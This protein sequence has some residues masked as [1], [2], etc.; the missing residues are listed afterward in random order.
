MTNTLNNPTQT[1][2][3]DWPS[4]WH[5]GVETSKLADDVAQLIAGPIMAEA[6]ELREQGFYVPAAEAL[7]HASQVF[8]RYVNC[9]GADL[10]THADDSD[11]RAQLICMV[12]QHLST[13]PDAIDLDWSNHWSLFKLK[14]N[15][16][17][18]T[19][20]HLFHRLWLSGQTEALLVNIDAG[21]KEAY[22][23]W[24]RNR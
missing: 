20:A 19:Q 16:G 24:V 4:G 8:Q 21:R 15:E 14:H 3:S 13:M 5:L 11:E 10:D 22:A 2:P 17:T 23:E 1:W 18:W 7:M 12:V 6:A 9:K